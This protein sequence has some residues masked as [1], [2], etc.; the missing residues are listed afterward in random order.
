MS[1][2]GTAF[3]RRLLCEALTVLAADAPDQVRWLDRYAVLADDIALDFA[4]AFDF[5]DALVDEGALDAVTPPVLR[6]IDR[7]LGAMSGAEHADRWSR[8]ALAVDPGWCRARSLAREVLVAELG[9]WRHPMPDI[10]VIR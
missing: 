8:D 2:P 1:I 6:E 9:E 3:R 4:H 10:T 5:V 7:L